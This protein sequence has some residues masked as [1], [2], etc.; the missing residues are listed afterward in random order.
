MK[1]FAWVLVIAA[2]L[3]PSPGR[4]PSSIATVD[5]G[6]A[7]PPAL[8]QPRPLPPPFLSGPIFDRRRL[9]AWE[10]ALPQPA[11]GVPAST[12]YNAADDAE[13][14]SVLLLRN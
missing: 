11:R 14:R 9:M 10:D 8:M 5:S 13:P 2:W 4:A 12:V 1:S 6:L 3:S 7:I